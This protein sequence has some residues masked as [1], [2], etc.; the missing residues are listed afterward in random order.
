MGSGGKALNKRVLYGGLLCLVASVSWGAMFPVANHAF[1]YVD[2][3]YFTIFRYIPVAVILVVLLWM[4]EG[5]RAFKTEGKG[6]SL[7]FFGTMGFTVYNLFIFWGQ[8][9][10]GQSGVL[11]ASVM[12]ALMPM[13]SILILWLFVGKKPNALSLSFVMLALIGVLLVITKGDMTVLMSN[14]QLIPV[15]A[16]FVSVVGWV[17]Y[18]MGGSRFEGWS[19]LRYSALTCLYG[20]ATATV[21]VMIATSFGIAEVPS[22]AQVSA[23]KWDI[24]FMVI[25]PGLIALLGWNVGVSILKPVNGL[26]FINF[27]PITTVVITFIQG[28]AITVYDIVGVLIVIIALTLHAIFQRRRWRMTLERRQRNTTYWS[29]RERTV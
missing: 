20:I 10:L 8:H 28:R 11:L 25:F 9:A 21:V 7:W 27:V 1:Q 6:R 13:I 22:V 17:L 15:L 18:T 16:L 23:I 5:S 2:P 3:F 14:H 26:L 29:Q 24:A 19:V 4:K 12:E